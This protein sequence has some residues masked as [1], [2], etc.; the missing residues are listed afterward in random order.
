MQPSRNRVYPS[1]VDRWLMLVLYSGPAILIPIGIY[2]WLNGRPDVAGTCFLTSIGLASFNC[3]LIW[4]CRYT[5]TD[6]ALNIRCG[7]LLRSVSLDRIRSADLSSSWG[8][9]PALSL[10]RVRIELDRGHR[11]VSPVD[12]EAFI[13]D[14]MAAVEQR[15]MSR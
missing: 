5:I 9:A 2:N 11:I 1:A 13:D 8:S 14:L 10:R 7:L 3:M 4:P 6:D 15:K 12:R